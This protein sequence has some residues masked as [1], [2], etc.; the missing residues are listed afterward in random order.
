M[1][2]S[3]SSDLK[4]KKKNKLVVAISNR[5]RMQPLELSV[6]NLLLVNTIFLR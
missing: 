4:K 1:Y 3:V 5:L 6:N 2:Y